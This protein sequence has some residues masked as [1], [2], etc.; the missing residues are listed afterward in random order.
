MMMRVTPTGLM[1]I[2]PYDAEVFSQLKQGADVSVEVKQARNNRLNAK[3]WAILG[4]VVDNSD[5]PSTRA[6]NKALLVEAKHIDHVRLMDGSL[7]VEPRSL[8]D[9]EGPEF[10]E[11]YEWAIGY[12]CE[13]VIP[14]LDREALEK[15]RRWVVR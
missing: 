2:G 7:L 14:G 9:L 1:P 12:I 5:W 3:Y 8:S 11:F 6:L 13:H 10:D 4:R 15:E